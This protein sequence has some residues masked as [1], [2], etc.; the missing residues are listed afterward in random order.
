MDLWD[1][2]YEA[3][4]QPEECSVRSNIIIGKLGTAKQSRQRFD[5]RTSRVAYVSVSFN[6]LR[7][8][9]HHAGAVVDP[10]PRCQEPIRPEDRPWRLVGDPPLGLERSR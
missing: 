7:S 1:D 2:I 9:F 4:A 8:S 6:K 5:R 3:E 10:E